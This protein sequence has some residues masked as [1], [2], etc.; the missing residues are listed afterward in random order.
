[1]ERGADALQAA[2]D[3]ARKHHMYV[4]TIPGKY[5]LYVQGERRG[6]GRCIHCAPS[7]TGI[8][9]ATRRACGLPEDGQPEEAF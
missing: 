5:L 6:H 7:A 1:M 9:K 2:K 3:L 8:L 4:V